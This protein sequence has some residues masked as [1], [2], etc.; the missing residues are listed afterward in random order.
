LDCS[1]LNLV[2]RIFLE[3]LGF[4]CYFSCFKVFSGLFLELLMH[5]KIFRKKRKKTILSDWA[6]PVGPTQPAPAQPAPPKPIQP[7]AAELL[8]AAAASRLGVRAP[9]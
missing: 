7:Q 9:A 4:S 8:R 1:C 5:W 3:F 2:L 6:E